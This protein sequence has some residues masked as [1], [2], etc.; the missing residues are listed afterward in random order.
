[1]LTDEV[2]AMYVWEKDQFERVE[3]YN[4]KQLNNCT[5][6]Y[7]S[8]TSGRYVW[9]KS[10]STIVAVYDKYTNRLVSFG[11]Y[12]NTT[13]QHVRKFRDML[14]KASGR[15]LEEHNLELVNWYK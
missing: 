11:R 6:W 4:W 9:L 13:Y 14:S 15:V 3:H 5:A 1:M 2:K 10:Y 8:L 12:S 7:T